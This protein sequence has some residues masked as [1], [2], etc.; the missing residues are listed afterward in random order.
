M[1]HLPSVLEAAQVQL[2]IITCQWFMCLFVN[3][4]KPEVVLRVWDMFLNE[5]WRL[6]CTE[7]SVVIG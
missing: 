5:G 3:T 1:L 4:L 2:P 6:L 7:L